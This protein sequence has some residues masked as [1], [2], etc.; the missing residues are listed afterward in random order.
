MPVPE[1]LE[2]DADGESYVLSWDYASP[3][4]SFR[5]Q[6]LPWVPSPDCSFTQSALISFIRL[7]VQ[8][9][10]HE[11]TERWVWWWEAGISVE[12]PCLKVYGGAWQS[13]APDS[14]PWPLYTS[15]LIH[16]CIH[17]TRPHMHTCTH[18]LAHTQRKEKWMSLRRVVSSNTCL[19]PAWS[20]CG[21]KPCLEAVLLEA[22]S[23]RPLGA[24]FDLYTCVKVHLRGH[25]HQDVSFLSLRMAD[26]V[27]SYIF[28]SPPPAR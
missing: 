15:Q 22:A 5:A 7:L 16:R 21:Q 3:N 23:Q 19:S 13:R 9:T 20:C 24:D 26:W 17:H 18:S 14:Q 1:N 12:A 2:L 8:L 6:W 25:V 27:L 4:V 11:L 10:A 28:K